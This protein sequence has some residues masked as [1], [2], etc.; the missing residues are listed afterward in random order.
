MADDRLPEPDKEIEFERLVGIMMRLR[1][2]NGCPWDRAQSPGSLSRHL[3]EEAYEVLEAIE[4]ESWGDL[5]EELGDLLLQIVFQAQIASEEGRFDIEDVVDSI[6]TKLERRHP[7]IF[8]DEEAKTPEEVALKWDR[9]KKEEKK[10]DQPVGAP[11]GI[12][13]LLAALKMQ[14]QAA[15]EGFDWT[16]GEDVFEKLEEEAR[17][18]WE[19]RDGDL[20]KL[21]DEIGDL[22]FTV[23]NISRHYGVDPEAA[24]RSACHKFGGR[25]RMMVEAVGEAGKDFS[26]MEISE[27]DKFWEKAKKDRK[28]K[29]GER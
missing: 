5:R 24:L 16:C 17:E 14:G 21:K 3:I 19:A 4:S 15:R 10:S 27:K 6:S 25:Y 23:V 9:I 26:D 8:G 29:K 11:P 12:P 18:L 28:R 13:A 7:H 1:G 2:E 20:K 22:L